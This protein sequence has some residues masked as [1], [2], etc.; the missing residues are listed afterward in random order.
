MPKRGLS[1]DSEA[2]QKRSKV[3]PQDPVAV[4]PPA[5]NSRYSDPEFTAAFNKAFRNSQPFEDPK[6]SARLIEYPYPTASLP[7]FLRST[8]YLKTLREELLTEDYFHKSNDLYE[9]Y[10]SEDL[11][12][13]KK[14]HIA[15]LKNAIYSQGFF[16]MMTS[17]T[18]IDLDPSIID[19]NGN[20]Y[21]EGCYLLCHDDDIKNEKEG[22]RI[23]FILY[24]VDEDWSAADGGALDLFKCNEAGYPIEVVQSLV[25]VRNTLAF[26]ELSS[27]S[28][29]QVAE[30]LTRDKSRISI[31][32]WFHGPLKTR[33]ISKSMPFE[34][35]VDLPEVSLEALLN[36]DYLSK[37]SIDNICNVF[38][39]QSSIELQQFL[40]PEI[41]KALLDELEPLD[42]E[43]GA[44]A[45]RPLWDEQMGP[46]H[47]RN[48]MRVST[49]NQST[50]PPTLARVQAL[51]SSKA[52]ETY[53]TKIANLSFL[54]AYTELRM[55]KKGDY[56]LL[57][58]HALERNGLD[59]VFSFPFIPSSKQTSSSKLPEWEESWGAG[60]THYVADKVNLL[61]LYPK[62]NT[63]TLVLRDE[64]TMR[65]VRFLN[66]RVGEARRRELSVLYTVNGDDDDE[67]EDALE[68]QGELGED[69]ESRQD[70]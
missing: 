53:M 59:V 16:A 62:H 66:A 23:A 64:G 34:P 15:A 8:T 28:Y 37:S 40:K 47:V 6:S 61:T 70:I 22:R 18:G 50:I 25:P 39:D 12:L 45:V 1:P 63:L 5:F 60:A 7:N 4:D 36:P 54:S 21:H 2:S 49:K 44:Q 43:K 42:A 27:V 41:Y 57:H 68:G 11:R 32:G 35:L 24:L 69:E 14:P 51:F 26:F 13:S 17:L 20:Q 38:S 56:T 30:V 19:L 65:F 31:S 58:D 48:Y 67:D 55:F 10:Q 33:L 29:H 46:R 52:F 3:R 9:F